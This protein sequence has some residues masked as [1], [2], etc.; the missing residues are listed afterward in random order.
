MKFYT[1]IHQ[2]SNEILERY[3]EDGEHKQRKI[4]YMPTLYVKSTRQSHLKTMHGEMV[5]PKM[6][7]SIREARNFIHDHEGISNSP[8]YGMQQFTYAYINE[9]YP[10]RE[11]DVNQL[12]IFNFDI[13]TKSDEGF[14]NIKEA[15]KDIL[16]IAAR[17]NGQSYILG[18]GD[19]KTTDDDI[20]IKCTGEND[21]LL[22]FI[23]LW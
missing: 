11:F 3:I 16:S 14:P 9:E 23:D 13:E 21:L 15:D 5:E 4:P 18:C 17:C 12:T 2:H 19:Y 1:S 10:Q 20:Y 22:K 8:I 6:F 7:N